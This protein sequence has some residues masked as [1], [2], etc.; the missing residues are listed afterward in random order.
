MEG[1]ES[2]PIDAAI[3]WRLTAENGRPR[4]P[5]P[6]ARQRA[7]EPCHLFNDRGSLPRPSRGENAQGLSW[8]FSRWTV[9]RRLPCLDAVHGLTAASFGLVGRG[10]KLDR[11]SRLARCDR[12]TSAQSDRWGRAERR[13]PRSARTKAPCSLSFKRE[14]GPLR[15]ASSSCP[16]NRH[17][18]PTGPTD[19]PRPLNL[20]PPPPSAAVS[21]SDRDPSPSATLL[22]Q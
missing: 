10:A 8:I 16:S 21:P 11:G 5:R 13:P 4:L 19:R 9:R 2:R 17:L 20:S 15:R 7:R 22:Y 12:L 18:R 3:S 6:K 1:Q 14:I